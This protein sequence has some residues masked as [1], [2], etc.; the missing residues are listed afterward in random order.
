M[1][2]VCYF[3]HMCHSVVPYLYSSAMSVAKPYHTN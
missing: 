2:Y 1:Y 3:A